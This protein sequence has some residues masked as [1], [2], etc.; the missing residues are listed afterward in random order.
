MTETLLAAGPTTPPTNSGTAGIDLSSYLVLRN[1]K[2]VSEVFATPADM[3]NLVVSNIF[4]V[5][6]FLLFVFIIVA[7]FK[8][9]SNDSKGMEEAKSILGAVGLGFAIMFGAYWIV[10]IMQVLTGVKILF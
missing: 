10:Q 5:S 6:G 4:V 3:V 8:F 9:I 1:G 7:G 2:K